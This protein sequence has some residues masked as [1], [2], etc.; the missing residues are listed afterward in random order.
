MASIVRQREY[1]L[2][3]LTIE[4]SQG[5]YRQLCDFVVNGNESDFNLQ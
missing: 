3:N 2:A 1:E 5:V 4:M